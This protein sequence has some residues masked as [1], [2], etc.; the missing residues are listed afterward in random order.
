[1]ITLTRLNGTPFV[2][3]AEI[4]K[5]VED[6]PD[7]VITLTTGERIVVQEPMRE[8]VRKSIEYARLLRRLIRPES[9]D[10][11]G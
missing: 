4:I 1:M 3:N 11:A 7:T 9:G 10:R 8:V 2:V 6:T 5:T